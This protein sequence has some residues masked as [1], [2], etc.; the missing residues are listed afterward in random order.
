MLAASCSAMLPWSR[1]PEG[2]ANETNV[3]FTVENNLL[4]LNTTINHRTGRFLFG[5]ATPRTIIDRRL[6]GELGTARTYTL[7]VNDRKTFAF[8]P[9]FLDLGSAADA[10]I[11]YDTFAPHAMTIDYR[12]GLLTLQT[13][14]IYT[15]MMSV[16]RFSGAP[17]IDVEVNGV[18]MSAVV[19][20]SLPDTIVIPGATSG[21]TRAQVVVAGNDFGS[22]DLRVGGVQQARIGNRLLSKFL[23][24]ID[25]NA[26]QIGM[27]RDPRIQ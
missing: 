4:F 25:Y 13:E 15:S 2:R 5:S 27:W 9:I 21:R 12:A 24:S 1:S 23:I 3:A 8:T 6:F 16:Y 14:G 26:G 11:G 22:V 10:I 17:A 20:T 7:N 19:D 18:R